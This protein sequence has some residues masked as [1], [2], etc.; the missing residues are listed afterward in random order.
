MREFG[1]LIEF[2]AHLAGVAVAEDLY[3]NKGLDAA[4]A[5]IEREAKRE[6]GTYQPQTGPFPEWPELAESTQDRREAMGYPPNDPLLV[7]GSLRDSISREVHGLDAAIG[8]TSDL[9][10][11]HEFGTSRMPARPVLG[12]AAYRHRREVETLIGQAAFLGIIGARS[13]AFAELRS[14]GQ[15]PVHESLGYDFAAGTNTQT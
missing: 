11:Y 13:F 10:I 5:V 3:L 1:S 14:G 2:S 12:P 7:T 4:A 6:F 8:S 9:M 15:L